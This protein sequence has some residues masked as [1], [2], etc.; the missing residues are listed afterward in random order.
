[1]LTGTSASNQ[2]SDR[3]SKDRPE[4]N[5][6]AGRT[7]SRGPEVP[8]T[9][10]FRGSDKTM[11][12]FAFEPMDAIEARSSACESLRGTIVARAASNKPCLVDAAF[13][14]GKLPAGKST[15]LRRRFAAPA[16]VVRWESCLA[17]EPP[18]R[19]LSGW[20]RPASSE[21]LSGASWRFS[22]QW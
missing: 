17:C 2:R 1:L 6:P 22:P 18:R 10:L 16:I 4:G 8:A 7:N 21:S 19:P 13:L 12:D 20:S 14:R 15:R 3:E 9:R 11:M 5:L